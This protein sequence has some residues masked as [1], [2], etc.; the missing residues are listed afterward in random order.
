MEKSSQLQLMRR[1]YEKAAAVLVWLGPQADNSDLALDRI[2]EIND[3]IDDRMKTSGSMRSV[4]GN[5]TESDILSPQD[6]LDD[7]QSGGLMALHRL[8]DRDWW[9]RTW[10][11]QEATATENTILICGSKGIPFNAVFKAIH[12]YGIL[13]MR[14]HL[15]YLSGIGTGGPLRVQLF[16]IQRLTKCRDLTF[17][18][19]LASVRKSESTDPRDKVFAM[20]SF[21]NDVQPDMLKPDYSSPMLQVYTTVAIWS[22]WTYGNLD[23]L[24]FC[25]HTEENF[26]PGFPSWLPNWND[27]S[28][29]W[30]F[31]KRLKSADGSFAKAYHAS[32]PSLPYELTDGRMILPVCD[33]RTVVRGW[34]LDSIS[35][36]LEAST[37]NVDTSIERSWAPSNGHERYPYTKETLDEAFRRTIVADISCT[38]IGASGVSGSRG[39]SMV[40]PKKGGFEQ[41]SEEESGNHNDYMDALKSATQ[42]RRFIVTCGSLMGLAPYNAQVDDEIFVFLGGQVLYILRQKEGGK[43]RFIGECYL[44]GMMDGEAMDLINEKREEFENAGIGVENIILE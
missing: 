35:Q 25:S 26:I 4:I 33:G 40:W 37:H 21:A 8:F 42:Y 41:F 9:F 34:R 17:L 36:C 38:K 10:I 19:L 22:V 30:P 5:V 29:Q 6:K 1:I 12:L 43:Y 44:H 39:F 20:L 28:E 11:L 31:I 15:E 3:W 18:D 16:K 23:F 32:G 27:R 13:S 7:P 24:G 14:P 2:M